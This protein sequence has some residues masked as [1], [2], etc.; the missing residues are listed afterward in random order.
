M[1]V[2]QTTSQRR[3]GLDAHQARSGS[4]AVGWYLRL[5]AGASKAESTMKSIAPIAD[6]PGALA[7]ACAFAVFVAA[8]L[9]RPDGLDAGRP[10]A[11]TDATT[12]VAASLV[13][14]SP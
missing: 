4:C 7:L 11:P 5:Q 10:A 14:A 6:L 12:G 8:A 3:P 13:P 9:D 2:A 1:W